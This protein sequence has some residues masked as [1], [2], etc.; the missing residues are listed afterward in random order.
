M[1]VRGLYGEKTWTAPLCGCVCLERRTAHVP[2]HR[3]QR[4]TN[5]EAGARGPCAPHRGALGRGV[6]VAVIYGASG[7][8]VAVNITYTVHN[9]HTHT[10]NQ[11]EQITRRFTS[12]ASLGHSGSAPRGSLAPPCEHVLQWQERESVHDPRMDRVPRTST[13]EHHPFVRAWR[14]I[15]R[16]G[17]VL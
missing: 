13:G 1:G 4:P 9:Q 3:Q 7:V 16:H 10:H 2:D 8:A 17:Q 6:A 11:P 15:R 12:K 5:K 14:L